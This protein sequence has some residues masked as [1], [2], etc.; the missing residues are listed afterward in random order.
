MFL[1][2]STTTCNGNLIPI[3][4]RVCL[5]FLM[6]L[7]MWIPISL[8]TPASNFCIHHAHSVFTAFSSFSVP[9]SSL[10]LKLCCFFSPVKSVLALYGW[11]QFS[12]EM[13][14]VHFLLNPQD[15]R[16]V[17]TCLMSKVCFL[18]FNTCAMRPTSKRSIYYTY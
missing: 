14:F 6:V 7:P 11:E 1:R 2:Y 17:K 9:S 3:T 8:M 10:M 13:K 4:H 18:G 5:C 12:H 16:S 15:T